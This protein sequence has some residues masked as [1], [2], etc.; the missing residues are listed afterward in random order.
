MMYYT[1]EEVKKHNK[2]DSLWIVSDSQVYDVTDFAGRHPGG[3]DVLVKHG[4][5]E[6]A[7]L[8]HD[9]INHQHTETA[10][11]ILEKY[12]IGQLDHDTERVSQSEARKRINNKVGVV[13][14]VFTCLFCVY[15]AR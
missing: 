11:Q 1:V 8:M 10:Y 9:V 7:D 15:L 6:V 14:L 4:G 3:L 12:H 5:D 13:V 2:S